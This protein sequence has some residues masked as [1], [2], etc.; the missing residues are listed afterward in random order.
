M[1]EGELVLFMNDDVWLR[2]DALAVH[3]DT[4][5]GARRLRSP[6]SATSSSRAQMPQTAVHRVVRAVRLRPGRQR[7]TAQPV[8][9][10]VLL[11]DEPVAAARGDARPPARLPRGL[12]QH[13]PRG[14]RARLPLEPGRLPD[15]STA[16]T[17][18]ASTT[19]PTTSTARAAS[20]TAS[21]AACATSQALI[22]DD[23]PA[24]ALRRLQLL[25]QPAL[26]RP[27]P[28]PQGPVQPLDR[29]AAAGPLRPARP[30]QPAGRVDATGRSCCTTPTAA[31]SSSRPAP[32]RA[33][34]R[35]DPPSVEEQAA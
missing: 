26:G 3:A 12:G 16:P 5:A 32:S 33:R 29:A 21:G 8:S 10:P 31:T 19:T 20:S 25:E 23:G 14:R 13:R 9:V 17:R 24:R 27:R 18:G 35:R 15:R 4:H 11:V 1:A 34:S 28:G 30:A 6:C 7:R 22:P 2:P